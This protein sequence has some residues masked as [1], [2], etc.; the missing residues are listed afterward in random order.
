M[1]IPVT[2][3]LTPED[4][5]ALPDGDWYELIDGHPV[6]KT[7]GAQSSWIGGELLAILRDFCREH[8]L[9]LVFPGDTGYQCFPFAV[10]L[11]RKP[12]VSF[13][14]RG[15]FP[16]GEPPTGNIRIAPDL[17][18]EVVSPN[19]TYY[20]VEGKVR[21]YLRVGVPLVWVVNPATRMVRVHRPGGSL[22]DLEEG[23]ELTGETVLPGFRCRVGDLFPKPEDGAPAPQ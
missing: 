4:L 3:T 20:E 22:T 6:E 17:A 11:V 10:N 13:I 21:E 8:N 5:L 7:M 18:V 19:D 12:D 15:R 2:Q 16:G 23:Q 1:N 9:G 14:R